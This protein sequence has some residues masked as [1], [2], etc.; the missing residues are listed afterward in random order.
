M[1]KED[2]KIALLR[3]SPLLCCQ[4]DA[5]KCCMPAVVRYCTCGLSPSLRVIRSVRPSPMST[6]VISI[7]GFSLVP[8]LL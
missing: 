2:S 7:I 8:P 1:R 3:I 4:E 5:W 6:V